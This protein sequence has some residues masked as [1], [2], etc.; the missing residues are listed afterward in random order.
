MSAILNAGRAMLLALPILALT[1]TA[2]AQ[3]CGSDPVCEA[4]LLIERHQYTQARERVAALNRASPS[5]AAL[6]VISESYFAAGDRRRGDA[7]CTQLARLSG[8]GGP[9]HLLC[10]ARS[11]LVRSRATRACEI[12]E[13]VPEL[14]TDVRRAALL[15]ECHRL[16]GH[17]AE[18]EAAFGLATTLRPALLGLAR[19]YRDHNRTTESIATYRRLL[20]QHPEHADAQLEL[21]QLLMGQG[22]HTEAAPLIEQAASQ[23]PESSTAQLAFA[24]IRM[25][26]G[27]AS[28]AVATLREVLRRDRRSAQAHALLGRALVQEGTSM[29]EAERELR[30]GLQ[31]VPNDAEATAALAEVMMSRGDSDEALRLLQHAADLSPTSTAALIRA[32]QIALEQGRPV[33]A[34]GFLRR[35]LL[36]DPNS[37]QVRSL[38]GGR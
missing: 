24:R 23:Q 19:L 6:F 8:R 15:G 5:E 34:T 36:I 10:Q 14:R 28:D 17:V 27:R 35:A 32:G 30:R 11:E 31:S 4:E 1:A 25:L 33:L 26:Q 7:V 21:G 38:L 13:R 29:A 37:E 18:A 20:A 16:Q 2:G 22:N 9:A 3:T 12:V